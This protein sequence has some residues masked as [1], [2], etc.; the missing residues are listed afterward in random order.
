MDNINLDKLFHQAKNETPKVSFQE[1]KAQFTN[2]VS[3][4]STASSANGTSSLFTIKTWTIMITTLITSIA[5]GSFLLMPNSVQKEIRTNSLEQDL[6]NSEQEIF[7][8]PRFEEAV[9]SGLKPR[10]KKYKSNQSTENFTKNLKTDNRNE[11]QF[12]SPVIPLEDTQ[13]KDLKKHFKTQVKA[14]YH[15]P[16]LTLK[17]I[18]KNNAYKNGSIKSLVKTLKKESR[19]IPSGEVEINGVIMRVGKLYMKTAEVTNID[20]RVFLFDLLIQGRKQEFREAEPDQ[21]NWLKYD[22]SLVGLKE[23]YF[24]HSAYDYYPVNNI[25]RKAAEM[26]CKWL[27]D[28]TNKYLVEKGKPAINEV[29]IPSDAEWTYAAMGG[30]KS[31]AYPWGGPYARNAKGCYL[32]NF[33]PEEGMDADGGNYPVVAYSYAPND[34]GMFCMSGNLAEM[35]YY[36]NDKSQPGTRGGSWTSPV[37]DIQILGEDKFKGITS[38]DVNIGFRWV[39][40]Y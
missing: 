11:N 14:E 3:K 26:Y 2:S 29:R 12:S 40:S 9:E 38:P 36:N 33:E 30:M 35:V 27:T 37:E 21:E 5:I 20:Y 28:E 7:I 13:K 39:V 23:M 10:L 25:S 15:Y 8:E 1:T 19:V 18:K 24:S 22:S 31:S 34:Y 17:E 4:L 16:T 32:A 6:E